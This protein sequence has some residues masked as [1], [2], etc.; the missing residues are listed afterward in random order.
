MWCHQQN[1][2]LLASTGS[3]PQTR[4]RFLIRSN[5]RQKVFIVQYRPT[6]TKLGSQSNKTNIFNNLKTTKISLLFFIYKIQK[7]TNKGISLYFVSS[8]KF[9][10]SL[11]LLRNRGPKVAIHY[12][13]IAA[14]SCASAQILMTQQESAFN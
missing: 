2:L 13:I 12:P 3:K 4:K 11:N 8:C 9:K 5:I 1:N 10:P 7:L 14:V 6:K